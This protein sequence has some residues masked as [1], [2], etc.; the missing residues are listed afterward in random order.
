MSTIE[1]YRTK[2]E[3]AEDELASVIQEEYPMGTP[4]RVTHDRGEFTGTVVD[5]DTRGCRI[6]VRNDG[7]EKQTW[8]DYR[9]VSKRGS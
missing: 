7:S 6:R 8:Q 5:W 3:C 9:K 2:L 1:Y 4:V